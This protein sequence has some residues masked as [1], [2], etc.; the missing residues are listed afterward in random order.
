MPGRNIGKSEKREM[1]TL[2]L[3]LKAEGWKDAAIGK[4][5]G[6][7][8]STVKTWLRL[9]IKKLPDID[10]AAIL[11]D[12][13]LQTQAAAMKGVRDFH[14]DKISG[15]DLV[16]ILSYADKIV[17][18][19]H[20]IQSQSERTES[21]PPLLRVELFGGIELDSPED[22]QCPDRLPAKQEPEI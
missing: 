9:Q 19:D 8:P 17:G 13:I 14:A 3:E 15:R 7:H 12:R 18:L 10:R 16:A 5:L 22:F 20:L 11:R 1:M 2:A 4:E 6:V 21:L